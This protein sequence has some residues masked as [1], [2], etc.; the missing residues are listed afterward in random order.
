MDF[1]LVW[2]DLKLL[3]VVL[4]KEVIWFLIYSFKCCCI[5]HSKIF[6]CLKVDHICDLICPLQGG[7]GSTWFYEWCEEVHVYTAAKSADRG[8]ASTLKVL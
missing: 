1:Q 6:E 2:A 3:R 8:F 7:G 4:G 5:F